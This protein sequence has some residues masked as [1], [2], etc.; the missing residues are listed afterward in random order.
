M[1]HPFDSMKVRLQLQQS[2]RAPVTQTP[3]SNSLRS[4]YRG[5]WPP[6]LTT[7]IMQSI[8]FGIFEKTKNALLLRDLSSFATAVA[9]DTCPTFAAGREA[10]KGYIARVFL[11]GATAGSLLTPITCPIVM[12]KLQQQA[13][14]KKG[15]IDAAREIF[16][17]RGIAAFYKGASSSVRATSS[18]FLCSSH[19]H[20]FWYRR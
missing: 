19:E 11:A 8:S 4:L 9:G 7:G 17:T 15:V 14:T 12:I 5:I 6:L 2:K 10:E 1:G 16:K 13:A 20:D 3:T 18:G